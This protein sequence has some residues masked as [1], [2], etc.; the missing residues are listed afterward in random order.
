MNIGHQ[1]RRRPLGRGPFLPFSLPLI[2]P[3]TP[4][5]PHHQGRHC[6]WRN[7]FHLPVSYDVEMLPD[8]L[9]LENEA[10][11]TKHVPADLARRRF[12]VVG[13]CVSACQ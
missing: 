5:P 12:V 10:L 3:P 9:S 4:Q 2:R 6:G 7:T 1:R 8:L 11:A 13:A